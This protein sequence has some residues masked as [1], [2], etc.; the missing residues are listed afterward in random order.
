MIKVWDNKE[1][2]HGTFENKKLA[3]EYVETYI[4]DKLEKAEED[5]VLY[6]Q[7]CLPD[8]IVSVNYNSDNHLFYLKSLDGERFK[9][10]MADGTEV[11]FCFDPNVKEKV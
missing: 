4:K 5:T 9:G 2:Q 7:R 6:S 8:Y 11:D 1:K 3:F 10:I